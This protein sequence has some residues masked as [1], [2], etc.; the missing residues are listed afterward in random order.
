VEL[1]NLGVEVV[2]DWYSV[3]N[4][5]YNV[6][7]LRFKDFI[8]MVNFLWVEDEAEHEPYKTTDVKV[9]LLFLLVS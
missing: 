2:E 4:I 6:D 8:C 3:G 1:L 9:I 7:T 5:E